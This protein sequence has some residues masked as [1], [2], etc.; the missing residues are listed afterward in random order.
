[1]IGIVIFSILMFV[2]AAIATD[3]LSWALGIVAFMWVMIL[4]PI[5]VAATIAAVFVAYLILSQYQT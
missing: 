4:F 2:G 3:D 1:M 5:W